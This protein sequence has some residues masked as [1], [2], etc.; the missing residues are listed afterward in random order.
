MTEPT[1][2]GVR[3]TEAG[4]H[5]VDLPEPDP[6]LGD[7]LVRVAACGICGSDL[8]M[9]EWGPMPFTYGHEISG[10]L[11]DG[12]PVAIEPVRPCG[13]C[14]QCVPGN[15]HRCRVGLPTMVG[16]GSDGG[17][18][19][20][21]RV[22]ERSLVALPDGLG[23]HNASLV[24][25]MAVSMHGLRLA[26]VTAGTSVAVVGAGSI[27][28]TAVAG[29]KAMGA[30]V[31]LIA[32]HP[33]QADAGR[34]IGARIVD[35]DDRADYDVTVEAAGSASAMET[36]ARLASPGA[37]VLVLGVHMTTLPVPG[38]MALMKELSVLSTIMYNRYGEGRRDVDDAAAALAADPVIARTMITHRFPLEQAAEAFRVAADRSSGAI[39]VVLE[40]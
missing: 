6:S 2:R 3:N 37:T 7:T 39:K 23:V 13:V 5:V 9:L 18:A 30:D 10:R 19:T 28:L 12:T 31:S 36:A 34:A 20:W 1:M 16:T 27:G 21:L 33:A 15:Y 8:H 24:E 40:P 11:T 38:V 29:A 14:D 26:G 4:L 25:P 17:M 32:R 35:A 22:P